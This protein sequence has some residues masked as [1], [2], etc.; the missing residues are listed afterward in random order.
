MPTNY[1]YVYGQPFGDPSGFNRSTGEAEIDRFNQW[2]RTQP[3]YTS[4][5]SGM[6]SGDLS[7][8]QRRALTNAMNAQG[9]PLPKDFIID[10][11]GN[12]NQKSRLGRNLAIAGVIGGTALGGLGLAGLG[13]LGALGGAGAASAG[14]TEAAIPSAFGITSGALPGGLAAGGLAAEGAALGGGA[15]ASSTI[16][17]GFVPALG[18]T[19]ASVGAGGGITSTLGNIGKA[20]VGGGNKNMDWKQ[21]LGLT[22]LG[23]GMDLLEGLIG[24][25]QPFQERKTFRGKK[26]VTGQDLDP[27]NAYGD[28]LGMMR[29]LAPQLK[30]KLGA[31]VQLKESFDWGNP[32]QAAQGPRLRNPGM[33]MGGSFEDAQRAFKLLGVM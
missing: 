26:S 19:G 6:G 4:L 30:A 24:N 22:G 27:G 25:T 15:L 11:G 9:I 3:W 28:A 8:D 18:G 21:M 14:A 32:N 33:K 1:G 16:G 5:R 13:P 20:A 17:S 10:S 23:T 31:P 7:K 29:D 2:M 12:L